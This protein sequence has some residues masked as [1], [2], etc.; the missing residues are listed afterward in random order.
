MKE[1][2][3]VWTNTRPRPVLGSVK[4]RR[5]VKKEREK[6]DKKTGMSLKGWIMTSASS[7]STSSSSSSFPPPDR[8]TAKVKTVAERCEDLGMETEDMR[9]RKEAARLKKEKFDKIKNKFEPDTPKSDLSMKKKTDQ[10][11]TYNRHKERDS[12]AWYG[13][14]KTVLN[15]ME[16][17]RD[18]GK[19][20][21]FGEENGGL[22]DKQTEKEEISQPSG[23]LFNS[24]L[25]ALKTDTEPGFIGAP[26]G[27]SRDDS[28]CGLLQ[29]RIKRLKRLLD[30]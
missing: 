20:R 24:K 14:K 9:K 23:I 11:L 30:Q 22:T 5:Q 4:K 17:G 2:N 21:K 26:Q 27:I 8:I 13:K 12:G 28:E 19:K 6:E 10:Q 16:M 29:G 18:S 25:N 3:D 1:W 7:S 15:G